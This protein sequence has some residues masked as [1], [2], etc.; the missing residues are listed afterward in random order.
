[1]DL[2]INPTKENIARLGHG[3]EDLKY[4]KDVVNQILSSRP[5]NHPTPIRVFSEDKKFKVDLMTSIFHEPLTFSACSERAVQNN[6]GDLILPV[7]GLKDLIEIKSNVKRYDGNMKDLVDAQ[8]LRKI[9]DRG[10]TI[11]IEKD[12]S[13]IKR[14]FKKLGKD[15]GM[16]M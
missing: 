6:L 9:L 2:W 3:L 13:I 1:M 15:K 14:I 10:K 11:T 7:I 12:P 16:S 4:S 5:I 8:E